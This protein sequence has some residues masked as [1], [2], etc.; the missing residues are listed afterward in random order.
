[1]DRRAKAMLILAILNEAYSDVRTMMNYLEDF[2]G[3][4][5]EME[6]E[7]E[8]YGFKG[9]IEYVNEL[10]RRIEEVM[11]RVKKDLYG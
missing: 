2:L 5:P 1:M 11:E 9:I 7:F 4:H 6:R 10:G 3:S 8:E